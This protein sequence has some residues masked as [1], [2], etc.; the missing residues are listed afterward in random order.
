MYVSDVVYYHTN[1]FL[2]KPEKKKKTFKRKIVSIKHKN[3]PL[4]YC[5]Q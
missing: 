1:D 3:S 4:V 2:I 5:E